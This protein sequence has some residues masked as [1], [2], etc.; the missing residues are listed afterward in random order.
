M[1]KKP[2]QKGTNCIPTTSSN[3][4]KKNLKNS[5]PNKQMRN[6]FGCMHSSGGHLEC[7]FLF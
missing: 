7:V 1:E 2:I 5:H 4:Q 6:I 3:S